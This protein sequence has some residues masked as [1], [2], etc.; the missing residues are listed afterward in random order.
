M[1]GNVIELSNL[2]GS[3]GVNLSIDP[4]SQLHVGILVW[5]FLLLIVIFLLS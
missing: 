1:F 5:L 3:N 4:Y 2:I